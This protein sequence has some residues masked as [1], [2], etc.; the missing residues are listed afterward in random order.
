M[1]IYSTKVA[2]SSVEISSTHMDAQAKSTTTNAQDAAAPPT[3]PKDAPTTNKL[4]AC[5][6]SRALMLY[7]AKAWH[8]LLIDLGICHKHPIIIEQLMNGFRAIMPIITQSFTPSNDTSTNIHY[9]AFNNILHK[10]LKKQQYIGP[11]TRDA[12]EAILRPFQSSPLSIIPKPGKPGKFC[13]I[14]N[15]SYPYSPWP[16]EPLSINA[17][18]D[19]SL[20]PCKWRSFYTACALIHTLPQGCEG[21]TRD[22]AKAYHTIL[23]HPSQWPALIVCITDKPMLFAVDTSLCFGY[24]PSAGI[25]GTV[26]D[27]SLDILRAVGIGPL[28]AWVNDHL[29]IQLPCNTITN[30]NE[31]CEAKS[32]TI[33]ANSRKINGHWWFKGDSLVDGSCEEFAENCSHL[34]KDLTLEHTGDNPASHAYDFTH[35]VLR[36]MVFIL[37]NFYFI[38]MIL[39]SSH[40]LLSCDS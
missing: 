10:E 28:I 1:A 2:R 13:L 8:D 33:T 34:I 19:P 26:Q 14:Q 40:D 29:F 12:L 36:I 17:Q 27:A 35:I 21:V 16:G 15:L 18:V 9:S 20:F 5:L 23:L 37:L 30:Y 39:D 22:I 38:T 6:Q 25:Y 31:L 24:G 4:W 7:K 32:Q 11:F 3:E